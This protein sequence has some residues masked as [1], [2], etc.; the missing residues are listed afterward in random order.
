M[1]TAP[2]TTA[3]D[4]A[5]D[6]APAPRETAE[7]VQD[8]PPAG[9]GPVR[10]RIA[11]SF[12]EPDRNRL[13]HH[14]GPARMDTVYAEYV[15]TQYGRDQ[16]RWLE[17]QLGSAF[18]GTQLVLSGPRTAVLAARTDALRKGLIS[19]EVLLLDRPDAERRIYCPHCRST[20]P[21]AA[22]AATVGCSGCR[23]TLEV[24][25]HFSRGLTAYLGAAAGAEER[26]PDRGGGLAG[27]RG[28]GRADRPA[29]E[30]AA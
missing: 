27:G 15:T 5:P 30:V 9:I 2:P 14:L 24:F 6:T 26:H 11:M 16:A 29:G 18:V 3:L 10:R 4:A 28:G 13:V 21:A 8:G 20:T 17:R 7:A 19:E 1:A 12:S 22:S 23:R 25:E